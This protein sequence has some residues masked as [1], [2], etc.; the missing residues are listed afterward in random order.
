MPSQENVVRSA[1]LLFSALTVLHLW[2]KFA[3]TAGVRR[4][5]PSVVN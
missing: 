3:R 1:F 5:C 2:L 4:A